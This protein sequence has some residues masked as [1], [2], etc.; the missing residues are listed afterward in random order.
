MGYIW[1]SFIYNDFFFMID[2]MV[3]ERKEI[4]LVFILLFEKINFDVIYDLEELFLEEVLFE[5]CVWR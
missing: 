4:E 3:L 2:F 1:E 5:V